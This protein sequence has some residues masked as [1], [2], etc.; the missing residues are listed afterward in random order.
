MALQ[1]RCRSG[2]YGD[3]FSDWPKLLS[4]Q[5]KKFLDQMISGFFVANQ[6]LGGAGSRTQRRKLPRQFLCSVA[7]PSSNPG[8]SMLRTSAPKFVRDMPAISAGPFTLRLE[9]PECKV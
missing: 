4:G 7:K 2:Y 6:S 3:E 9:V 8:R 5:L 1:H